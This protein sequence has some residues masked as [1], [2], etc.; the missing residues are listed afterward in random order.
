MFRHRWV[1]ALAAIATALVLVAT[2]ADAR[3]GRG[4]SGGSRGTRTFSAPAPTRTAP[5]TAAPIQSSACCC[6]SGWS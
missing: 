3:A 6:K 4:F 1:I 5:N 2:D